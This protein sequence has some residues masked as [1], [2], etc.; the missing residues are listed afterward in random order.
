[1]HEKMPGVLLPA[2]FDG[3]RVLPGWV[4]AQAA[5]WLRTSL[6]ARSA[7]ARHVVNEP[8]LEAL[9]APRAWPLYAARGMPPVTP[10]AFPTAQAMV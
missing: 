10:S 9:S 4:A 8:A 1:M 6:E 5:L 3:Q 7:Q 2:H